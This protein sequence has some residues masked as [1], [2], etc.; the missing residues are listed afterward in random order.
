MFLHLLN[1]M[2]LMPFITG[3]TVP[4]LNQERMRAIE[5]PL[6]PLEIQQE[7][8]KNIEVERNQVEAA[9]KLIE[10]YEARTQTVISKLWS[11]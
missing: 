7:L 9:S 8:A 6:P 2:D 3:V 10:A 4:K 1:Q 5:I 11:E